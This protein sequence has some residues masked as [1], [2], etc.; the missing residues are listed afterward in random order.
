M[1]RAEKGPMASK[2]C[3]LYPQEN[4][5]KFDLE[6]AIIIAIKIMQLNI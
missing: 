3:L 5:Q 1:A 2:N 4:R 6:I